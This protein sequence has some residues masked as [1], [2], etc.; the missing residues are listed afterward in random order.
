MLPL[1]TLTANNS[2]ARFRSLY[3]HRLMIVA[4][5]SSSGVL[6]LYF[7][8]E[9]LLHLA[10]GHGGITAEHVH[11][12]WLVMIALVGML[13]GGAAGQITSTAFYAMGNTTT[14]T[15]LFILTYTI[16]LPF[17]VLAFLRYGLMGLAI[18]TSVHLIVNFTLQ[19]IVLERATAPTQAPEIELHSFSG[20]E[21]K[22]RVKQ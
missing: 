6:V 10:I 22:A 21:M 7:F 15:R 3:R 20:G 8:G 2:W 13:A 1:L 14:P 5:L 18:A 19:L 4:G 11:A 12:L 16:Y 17:K 9:P